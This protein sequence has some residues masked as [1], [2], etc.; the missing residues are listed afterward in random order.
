M[1]T[2]DLL[3]TRENLA[4]EAKQRSATKIIKKV[5]KTELQLYISTGWEVKR[6]LKHQTEIQQDKKIGDAFEDEVWTVFYKMGFKM[7]NKSNQ[8]E[9]SYTDDC[10]KQIDVIAMD[11]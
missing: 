6:H 2:W 1:S 3:L 4:S 5:P 10:T 11:D 8:F 7:L 9:L